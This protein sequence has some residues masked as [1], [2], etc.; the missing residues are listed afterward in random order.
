MP[1]QSLATAPPLPLS[2]CDAQLACNSMCV[3]VRVYGSTCVSK[4]TLARSREV[5]TV[6]EHFLRAESTRAIIA[7]VLSYSRRAD[8]IPR[9]CVWVVHDTVDGCECVCA[10]NIV[11]MAGVCVCVGANKWHCGVAVLDDISPTLF[12]LNRTRRPLLACI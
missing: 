10:D 1:V 8:Y 2:R 7:T 4:P 12:F 6:F 5:S 9:M 3:C 11:V